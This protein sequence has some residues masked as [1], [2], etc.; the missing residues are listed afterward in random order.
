MR[1]PPTESSLLELG[2]AAAQ[3]ANEYSTAARAVQLEAQWEAGVKRG[4]HP[5]LDP[6]GNETASWRCCRTSQ[7]NADLASS[8]S[9]SAA[10]H[11]H[12]AGESAKRPRQPFDRQQ[13]RF[14]ANL[15]CKIGASNLQGHCTCQSANSRNLRCFSSANQPCGSSAIAP[16]NLDTFR[17]LGLHLV[18]S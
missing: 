1:K 4:N 11:S 17:L 7:T 13:T 8:V 14:P 5:R 16:S 15:P 18:S 3:T 10:P 2:T 6:D 12:A 9:K